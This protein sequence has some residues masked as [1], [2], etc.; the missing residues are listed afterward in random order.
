MKTNELPNYQTF[1]L[2]G[3]KHIT[4]EN[5]IAELQTENA[6]MIDVRESDELEHERFKIDNVVN[7]PMSVIL[8]RL[9]SVPRDLNIIV[10]CHVGE[11]SVKVANLLI[12]QGFSSVANLDGGIRM[13]KMFGLP[14]D[15]N[16]HEENGGCG[17]C[18]QKGCC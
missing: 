5:A 2:D 11:R 9:D 16:H 7:H 4:P 17:C 6:L 14:V 12:I 1:H 8:D 10:S 18:D 3:V 15:G 13:W